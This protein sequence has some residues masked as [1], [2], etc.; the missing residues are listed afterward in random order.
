MVLAATPGA[1]KLIKGHYEELFSAQS[2]LELHLK[3]FP[4][5]WNYL[6][7]DSIDAE[8]KYRVFCSLKCGK[9]K[10]GEQEGCTSDEKPNDYAQLLSNTFE[11]TN[12]Q[13]LGLDSSSK[14]ECCYGIF[15]HFLKS[16]K[17]LDRQQTVDIQKMVDPMFFQGTLIRSFFQN[18]SQDQLAQCFKILAK[19]QDDPWLVTFDAST[20]HESDIQYIQ[21]VLS[22][23]T[24]TVPNTPSSQES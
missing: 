23:H 6:R 5:F 7:D 8:E 20:L 3:F 11:R 22:Q 21:G 1:N 16:L 14:N 12:N 4:L 18:A 9:M 17:E 2:R 15:Q 24:S 13:V 10:C 19:G